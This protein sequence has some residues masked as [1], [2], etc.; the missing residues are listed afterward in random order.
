MCCS[1]AFILRC[2]IGPSM[3]EWSSKRLLFLLWHVTTAHKFLTILFSNRWNDETQS[4]FWLGDVF[5]IQR[6]RWKQRVPKPK[7]ANLWT[8]LEINW[9][10]EICSMWMKWM[11]AAKIITVL[12]KSALPPWNYERSR[13]R[14][15]ESETHTNR[16]LRLLLFSTCGTRLFTPRHW[17]LKKIH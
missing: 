13:E 12:R 14:E 7:K 10:A 11:N 5:D 15:K 17:K 16:H 1:C 8:R 9:D 6:R 4:Q 2:V 3:N